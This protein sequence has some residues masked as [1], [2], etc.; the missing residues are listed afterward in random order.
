[1]NLTLFNTKDKIPNHDSQV[2]FI[3]CRE[4]SFF[5]SFE[6]KFGHV[7]Y[8]WDDGNG[9][10]LCSDEH[11]PEPPE[12]DDEK[13]PFKLAVSIDGYDFGLFADKNEQ[14]KMQILW[15]YYDDVFDEINKTLS[16]E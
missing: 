6:F 14:N 9:C 16:L 10:S 7:E 3:D 8:N 11:D 1:M 5:E 2:V 4:D 13:Y 12:S 15:A